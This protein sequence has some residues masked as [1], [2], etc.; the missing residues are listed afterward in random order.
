[1]AV[2]S[3]ITRLDDGWTD[4]LVMNAQPSTQQ[5]CDI[6]ADLWLIL[7]RILSF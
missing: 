2:A 5:N 6:Y 4:N 3:L 1:M 7:S